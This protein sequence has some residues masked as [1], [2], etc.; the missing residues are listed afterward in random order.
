MTTLT[1]SQIFALLRE[2][3][4]QRPGLDFADYGDVTVYRYDSRRITQQL[5]DAKE[6]LRFCELYSVDITERNFSAFS[7][8]LSLEDGKLSYCTGQYWPTEYRAAVCAVLASAVWNYFRDDCHY[9]IGD[10]IRKQAARE[11]GRGI[12]SRWFN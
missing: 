7:G 4:S 2:F 3:V 11:F 12:A 9:E 10:V 5:N 1:K 8:R 6:M